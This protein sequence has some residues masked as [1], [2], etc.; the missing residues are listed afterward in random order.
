M[1]GINATFSIIV[2]LFNEEENI[3]LFYQKLKEAIKNLTLRHEIIF[4]DDGSSDMTCEMLGR[5]KETDNEIKIIKFSRNFGQSSAFMAGFNLASG[6]L[7][8]TIDADLQCDPQYIPAIIEELRQGADIVC[9]FRQINNLSKFFKRAPSIIANFLGALVF[10]LK[11][12]DFSCSFRGYT[13][14]FYKNL[15][16]SNGLHRF[17]PVFAKFENKRIK[18]IKINCSERKRGSSKYNSSRFP[19]VIKDAVFLKISELFFNK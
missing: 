8:I 6:D 7:A 16:L 19:K 4:I 18:E 1:S 14:D 2:P 13:K 3:V 9:T 15:I 12:H 11:I 5:L 10:N 17:I